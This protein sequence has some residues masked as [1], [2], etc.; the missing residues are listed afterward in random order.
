MVVL[1]RGNGQIFCYHSFKKLINLDCF[2]PFLKS[3]SISLVHKNIYYA[4]HRIRS[5][6]NNAKSS[7]NYLEPR[8]TTPGGGRDMAIVGF[9]WSCWSPG[10][11]GFGL[12]GSGWWVWHGVEEASVPG[13]VLFQFWNG[14]G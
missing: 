10:L 5:P 2:I 4:I 11:A 3:T 1:P 13:V 14:Q 8:P 9:S 12:V 6:S 7:P